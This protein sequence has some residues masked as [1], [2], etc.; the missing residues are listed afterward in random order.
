M[1]RIWALEK[2]QFN[3]D[4]I[5]LHVHDLVQAGDK[6]PLF[7]TPTTPLTGGPAAQVSTPTTHLT[8]GPAAEVCDS[9]IPEI[10]TLFWMSY[11]IHIS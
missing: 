3:K 9:Y 2:C 1:L 6:T 8:G 7:E 4:D 5:K 10:W 11:L